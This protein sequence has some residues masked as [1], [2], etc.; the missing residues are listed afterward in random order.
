MK[1]RDSECFFILFF[2]FQFKNFSYFL[3]FAAKLR[4]TSFMTPVGKT[5]TFALDVTGGDGDFK[6]GGGGGGRIMFLV[7]SFES[8]IFD[9]KSVHRIHGE[10]NDTFFS[11]VGIHG[12][13]PGKFHDSACGSSGGNGFLL[14]FWNFFHFFNMSFLVFQGTAYFSCCPRGTFS[15]PNEFGKCRVCDIGSFA[16]DDGFLNRLFFVK[17]FKSC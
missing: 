9:G 7:P 12:G 3:I 4:L 13:N 11:V 15:D 1:L 14:F 16:A 8:I 17:S 2:L 6:G 5:K 10:I